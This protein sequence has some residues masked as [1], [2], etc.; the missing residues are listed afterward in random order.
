MTLGG[1]R[2]IAKYDLI[3]LEPGGEAVIIDWKTWRRVPPRQ[4]LAGRMQTILYRYLLAQAGAHLYGGR[5]IPP[6]RIRMIYCF[7]ALGAERVE[8][9]YSLSEMRADEALLL[10]LL[11]GIEGAEEFPLT[12]EEARC[13][14]C[15]YRSLCERGA[16]G[17]VD[18][19]D[20]FD[21]PEE[22]A[23]ALDFDQIAEIEF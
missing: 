15:N 14:F 13:R 9:S 11:R 17:Q 10:E 4:R 16:A 19:L 22:E 7:V 5:P 20:A 21:E 2:L 12:D 23:V 1:R 8:F 18:E 3:A 6:E